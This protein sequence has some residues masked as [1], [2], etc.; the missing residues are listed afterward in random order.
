MDSLATN[1]PYRRTGVAR[2][3][4]AHAQRRALEM[5]LDAVA[6]DTWEN[7]HAALSLYGGEGFKELGRTP[8]RGGLPGGVLLLKELQE[9]TAA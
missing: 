2:A 9:R 7:N 4:L 1:E 6:L 3:L 8:G 5:G